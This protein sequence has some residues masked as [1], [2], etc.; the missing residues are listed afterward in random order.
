MLCPQVTSHSRDAKCPQV[1]SH[2]RDA[3]CPQVTSHSRDVL[4]HMVRSWLGSRVTCLGRHSWVC[5]STYLP[6][7]GHEPSLLCL[8]SSVCGSGQVLQ[9]SDVVHLSARGT[10]FPQGLYPS[11]LFYKFDSTTGIASPGP[12]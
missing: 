3:K 10:L 12:V 11:L 5:F 2:S 7:S 4:P 6:C 1:T 9:S 8:R